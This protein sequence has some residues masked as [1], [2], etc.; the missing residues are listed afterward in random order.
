MA[1]SVAPVDLK[2]LCRKLTTTTPELLPHHLGALTHHVLRCRHVLSEPQ[3][4]SKS[5]DASSQS[6]VSV[7]V[8][9]LKTSITTLLNGRSREGRFAATVLIK[10]VVDVGGWEVLRTAEPWVRGLL[11][12]V[13]VCLA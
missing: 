10:A 1:S 13:Q 9:K 7:L 3:E 11:S 5:K 8:H 2:V 6:S 12:I 4:P